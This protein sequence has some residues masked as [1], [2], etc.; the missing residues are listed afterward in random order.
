M[1]DYFAPYHALERPARLAALAF[2]IA[3]PNGMTRAQVARMLSRAGIRL[4]SR[5][6]SASR[7]RAACGAVVAAGI[8]CDNGRKGALRARADW[9]PWLTLRAWDRDRLD[10]I[11]KAYQYE[12]PAYIYQMSDADSAML[13]R[14]HTVAARFDRIDAAVRLVQPVDWNWLTRPGVSHLLATLP[15]K[16]V[17]PAFAAC[18]NETVRR[19][20]PPEPILEAFR[21]SSAEP[22]RHAA[23][24]AF[25]RVLQGD[26]DEALAVFAGLPDDLRESKPARC[27][28]AAT[29]ALLATL[30]G[31]DAA[32][33]RHIDDAIAAEKAGTRKRNVFPPSNAFTLSLLSLV[34]GH[35]PANATKVDHLLRIGSKLDLDRS[36]IEAVV[37]A[38][39]ARDGW[40]PYWGRTRYDATFDRF[41]EGMAA[42]WWD[43][44]PEDAAGGRC[45]ALKRYGAAAA[46]SGYRWLAAECMEIIG[47]WERAAKSADGALSGVPEPAGE[48]RTRDWAALAAKLHR[49][50]GTRTLADVAAPAAEWELALRGIE[51]VAF[52]ARK[53]TARR[54]KA[55]VQARS[56]LAWV[57]EFSTLG[58]VTASAMEQRSTRAGGWT[59]GRPVSLKRLYSQAGTMDFLIDQDRAAAGKIVHNTSRWSSLPRYYL[60]AAGV[61]ALAGHP[62]VVNEAGEPVEIARRDPELLLRE[63]DGRL[64]A[65]VE[66]HVSEASSESHLIRETS[67]MRLEVTRYT[68]RHKK[69]C[70]VIPS[71]GV[72]LP[73]EARDRLVEAVSAMA[74]E[75]RVQGVIGDGAGLARQ[76][77]ADP[78]PWV[79]LEPSGPG[80][81]VALLV[82]PVA[83]SGTLFQPGVG[84][85]AVFAMLDGQAA[86]A[87]RNLDAETR[88]ARELML[89]CSMLSAVGPDATLTLPDPADCLELVDQ[90]DAA[91][92]RC[93]WPKGQPFR[94]AARADA[95]SLRLKVKSA[96]D[97]F[98]ASG[99]L[100]VGAEQVLGLRALLD[101]IDRDPSSRFVP[102]GEGAFISL[103][104]AFQQQLADLRSVCRLKG[105]QGVTLHG[106]AALTLRD[107]FDSTELD[108]DSGW[109]AQRGKFREAQAFEPR[110]PGTLQ[111]ELRPYQEE[112]FRWLARL[113]RLGAGAC[114]ADDMGLGKTV[115]TLAAL[116]DRGADGAALVVAPTSVVANW[117]DEARRFAPTLKVRP[118]TGPAASRAE[119]LEDLGP[120]DLV[121]TTY[122]LLHNDVDA[123]AEAD[124]STVVLDEAQ[125]I[126]N[127]AT[128]RARAARKLPSRFRLVTTGTP[129]Q[130]NVVDLYSL[131]S[132]LNP[133]MLG[134]ARRF[135]ENFAHPI[136][137]DRDPEA[138]TRLRRLI[139]PYVLRRIKSD[140]LDD[141][142]P[143]T[144]VTLQVEMS[145]EEAA[146]YEALRLRAMEDLE[147]LAGKET[148]TE[149][150]SGEHRLQVLAHLTK[151]R[152]ACCNPKLVHPG[153]PPSSKL[154]TFATTLDELRQGRHKV[155]VFSQFV[156]HLKLIEEHLTD[157]GVPYQ[158]LDG[159]TPAKQRSERIAAFQAGEG[160]AFLISLKAG[161]V[162]LNLT[163]ADY[164]IHMDPWWNPAAEDQASDRAH[165]IGQTRPVTIYRLVTKGT[166]EEQ[167]VDLHRHKRE[168]ADR[169][170]E[171]AD[172]PG[173]LSTAEL[174]KLLRG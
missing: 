98:S 41:V 35:T 72:E 56:R 66:P 122:G 40:S 104:A 10:P 100:D 164:V 129:I 50:L 121:V 131:F 77:K 152:L 73:V 102:L 29:H 89:A 12:F 14:C 62:Y 103:T 33:I 133:G 2:G 8:V 87:Q 109:Q 126:K 3:Y 84:G 115:Q 147:A 151:L 174:L 139:A 132:F 117:L 143:R 119:K 7:Y 37:M 140:V 38:V 92:A 61:F 44:F 83:G 70:E 157:T 59:K 88:A 163:A 120:F 78:G 96:A 31:D 93:L 161:G 4:E 158:Y 107:F 101:L 144:E 162:G 91:N 24:V 97:W 69:L 46:T 155:L 13:L 27:G 25:I 168:L 106:L 47:R 128:K 51:Q 28:L 45:T 145:A 110:M 32:A 30:R 94:V 16:H 22:A 20:A 127:P 36:M 63:R 150:G 170:L 123:L 86:Q 90:L 65:L 135:R 57:L 52:E 137:R 165:R 146:L 82:E 71:E 125:A 138:R 171:G 75:I 21:D 6:I 48:G 116:L 149:P 142:P 160:D 99:E 172:A 60:P 159:S 19:A 154:E 34:R 74:G 80:L 124:W 134:S 55:A 166:I 112:G 114:L 79:R 118:Y 113:S 156:R 81:T 141:L 85:T 169:L 15:A 68:A 95:G 130:N 17:D 26:K 42:C 5:T 49:E 76:V 153:G 167:I 136:E 39:R 67:D 64:L 105:K 111:A 43:D 58:G 23:A 148:G 1:A 9:A 108:A 54:K 53:K 173:R 18:F 11:L